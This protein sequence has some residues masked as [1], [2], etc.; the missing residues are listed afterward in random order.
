MLRRSSFLRISVL[1]FTVEK[2][3]KIVSDAS[4]PQDCTAFIFECSGQ[5][6]EPNIAA[7]LWPKI[8]QH[9]WVLSEKLGRDV[10]MKVACLDFMENVEPMHQDLH[11][12]QRIQLLKALGAQMIDR[13]IWDTISETQP[14][15]QIVNRRIILPLTAIELARKHAVIP[16]RTIIF[17]GPPGTGK[18]HFVRAIAGILQWWYIEVSP[19]TLMADGE[20]R[21]GANLKTLTDKAGN[22]DEVVLFIDE[23]EEI[24]GSRDHASRIDK[25]ITNEFLKQV[26]LLKRKER[27]NLLVCAT[28][29]IRQLDKALLR[30]GRFDCII[31]VGGLDDQGR[32]TIFEHYLW[33]TNRGDVDVDRIISMIALFTPADIEYLVQKVRQL[34]FEREYARG[35]DYRVTTETFLEMIPNVPPTLTNE[36]IEDFKQDCA[37]YTRY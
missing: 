32:R 10:G 27:K 6:V 8:M 34:A 5:K 28:N 20:D 35:E 13:S 3:M 25:S 22:L 23:F 31:P 33:N 30:P 7:E 16:P 21:L 37:H 2:Y 29:Y 15:K 4:S 9:K 12:A 14:P 26:P 11:D 36:I 18:T 19:S 1:F 17:F 24:A